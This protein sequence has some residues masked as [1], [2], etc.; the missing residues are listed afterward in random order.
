VTASS[1]A[2][3]GRFSTQRRRFGNVVGLTGIDRDHL[4]RPP[5]VLGERAQVALDAAPAAPVEH[6]DHAPAI[7]IGDHRGKLAGA[8]VMGLVERPDTGKR[9]R[10]RSV[11]P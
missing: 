2:S 1:Y 10:A 9:A 5:L 11:G 6:L 7:Q 3:T 8:A 4:D